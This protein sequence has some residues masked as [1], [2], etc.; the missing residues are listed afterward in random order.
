MTYKCDRC[1]GGF[2]TR[3]DFAFWAARTAP[4]WA[5]QWADKAPEADIDAC[6]NAHAG[7]HRE[8]EMMDAHNLCSVARSA[9]ARAGIKGMLVT[10][11]MFGADSDLRFAHRAAMA[12]KWAARIRG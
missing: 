2:P 7:T 6:V 4:R 8:R 12:R 1:A 9:R 3:I 11:D 10:L 5:A